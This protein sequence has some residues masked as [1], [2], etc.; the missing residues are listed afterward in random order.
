MAKS[1]TLRV[2]AVVVLCFSSFCFPQDMLQR[3]VDERGLK[4]FPENALPSFWVVI[5]G[6]Q[7]AVAVALAD[8]ALERRRQIS[9]ELH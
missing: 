6:V 7:V 2:I 8:K 9:H 1:L 5:A 4:Y 3:I